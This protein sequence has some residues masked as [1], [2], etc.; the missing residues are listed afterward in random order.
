M[1]E[2]QSKGLRKERVKDPS[3]KR[4]AEIWKKVEKDPLLQMR[5]DG[6]VA[7]VT[8]AGRG[9]G[10]HMA[11]PLASV[12]ADIGLIARTKSQLEETAKEI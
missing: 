9:L 10:R 12:G 1:K 11:L 4:I 8:G 7:I 6:K 2:K 3:R 5:L